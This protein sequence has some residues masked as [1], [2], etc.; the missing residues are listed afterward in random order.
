MLFVLL[1]FRD[2]VMNYSAL[3]KHTE[4]TSVVWHANQE[5]RSEAKNLTK[6]KRFSIDICVK[7]QQQQELA[8][9]E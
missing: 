6:Y 3:Y 7:Q 4:H 2:I 8:G 1:L 5:A 9:S